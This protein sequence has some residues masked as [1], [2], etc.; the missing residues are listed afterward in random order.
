MCIYIYVYMYVYLYINP[1]AWLVA[2]KVVFE[3]TGRAGGMALRCVSMRHCVSV[4]VL[5]CGTLVIS[6]T[7]FLLV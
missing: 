3:D 7:R 1:G 6:V 4:C 2:Q 5:V